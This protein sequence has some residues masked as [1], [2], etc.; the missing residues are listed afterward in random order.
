MSGGSFIFIVVSVVCYCLGVIGNMFRW[1]FLCVSGELCYLGSLCNL[2]SGSSWG[3]V[4]MGVM[5]IMF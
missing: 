1:V 4:S 5:F 3:S 2:L